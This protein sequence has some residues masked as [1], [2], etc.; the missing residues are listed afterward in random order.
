MI[1]MCTWFHIAMP[2]LLAVQQ[3]VRCIMPVD[4]AQHA[5]QRQYA[6]LL[7]CTAQHL[8]CLG[9]SVAFVALCMCHLSSRCFDADAHTPLM[10]EHYSLLETANDQD[11]D[12]HPANGPRGASVTFY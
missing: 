7:R 9:W 6:S 4:A 5:A 10:V 11:L 3:F 2:L 1:V 8:S 12:H